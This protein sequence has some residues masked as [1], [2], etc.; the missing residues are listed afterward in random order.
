MD[1]PMF[2][3]RGNMSSDKDY[4]S[5][6]AEV[7][8]RFSKTQAKAMVRVNTSML[9]FYWSIGRDLVDMKAEQ[10]WGAGIVKQFALDMRNA[11]PNE[12]GFSL[13]NV[14]NMK[15]WY[16]FY[17]EAYTKSQQAV[18]QLI[19]NDQEGKSLSVAGGGRK[20]YR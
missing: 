16:L 8:Q 5:W 17:Y 6:L 7:K 10:K 14:K 1:K 9:E 15:R 20:N 3:T 19:E 2:V 4:I 12:S 11:Y 18:D 13:T